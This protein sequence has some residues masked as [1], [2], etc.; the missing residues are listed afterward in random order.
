[1]SFSGQPDRDP[2]PLAEAEIEAIAD[3]LRNG[4]FVDDQYRSRLFR[5]SKEY[6]LQYQSKESKGS[7]LANTLG[8]PLQTVKQFGKPNG[9]W[10]NKLIFG[11]NLQILKTLLQLKE[12]G[13][14]KNAD[15]SDGVRLCYIDPPF[16]TRR[17]FRGKHDELAYT[18]KVIGA[19]FVEFLRKR[20]ILI[21]EVLSDD[22]NL[23]IHLDEKKSHYIKVILDEIFGSNL[24]VNEI[25][26]CFYGGGQ[27]KRFFPRKHEVIFWYAKSPQWYSDVDVIRVP[28]DS[29]YKATVFASSDTRAPGK[30]YGPDERGKIPEDWW[31]INRPYGDEITGYPTQKP[32]ALLERIIRAASKPGDL[33]LD[34]FAGSGTT[35]LVAD[36]LGRRWIAVDSGKF[37]IYMTQARLHSTKKGRREPVKEAKPNPFELCAAGLYDN[38]LI[39]ELCF[40]DFRAFSLQLF[41][42]SDQ[43][44]EIA[45]VPMAGTRKGAPVHLFPFNET[46][47]LM[48]EQYI[49]SLHGRIGKLVSGSVCVVV[50]VYACEPSLFRD[51]IELEVGGRLVSYFIL[52]VPYSVIEALH[53]RGFERLEQPTNEDE[54]NAALDGYGF[55]FMQ[56]PEVKVSYRRKGN[57]L[58]AAVG[59]FM[60]GG[61]DPDEFGDLPDA[62][63]GDLAMVMVDAD[64]DDGV[65]NVS[66]FFFGD[67]LK[68]NDWTF[69]I[70]TT[71]SGDHLLFIYI[72]THGNELREVI[73]KTGSRAAAAKKPTK[74]KLRTTK[75]PG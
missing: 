13:K 50:P 44:H 72:D 35:P 14:L 2:G 19:R 11:D 68:T 29:E 53:E 64:E 74:T 32:I 3:R 1:M 10:A 26:R 59:R 8:V 7:I 22:G 42:C 60:R 51:V 47:A 67:D 54:V 56:P 61:L 34:C 23:F 62:G 66:H 20:L 18:D 6:E 46:D 28:Y 40:D 69:A 31:I 55:D 75:S 43:P 58:V 37:A 27:G 12:A 39:E 15:G 5:P 4:E 33:V 63:R 38:D 57:Q 52:R 30:T 48:G 45:G 9:A 16:A 36:G 73:P 49:E 71:N 41:G 25:V 24:C 17:E 21:R 65:F 70:D